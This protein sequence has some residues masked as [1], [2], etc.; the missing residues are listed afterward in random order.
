M[1]I[2]TTTDDK[3]AGVQ[4]FNNV[5]KSLEGFK[6]HRDLLCNE[7]VS[8]EELV[9]ITNDICLKHLAS[10]FFF[11]VA[12]SVGVTVL[13]IPGA[14]FC[15]NWQ[16]H[17]LSSLEEERAAGRACPGVGGGDESSHFHLQP[18]VVLD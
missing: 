10:L 11:L 7:L 15:V 8:D 16:L 2:Q 17:S 13:W 18:A 4:S 12:F 5:Q 1:Q 14:V 6:K 3:N 9:F